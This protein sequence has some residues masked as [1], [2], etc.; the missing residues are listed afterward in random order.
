MMARRGRTPAQIVARIITAAMGA[1]DVPAD[2]LAKAVGVHTNTV[3]RDLKEPEG[4]PMD[5]MWLYFNALHVPIDEGL[6]AFADSF[7]RFLVQ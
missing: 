7:A 4:M 1:Q 5:R 6:Q 3:R 2:M